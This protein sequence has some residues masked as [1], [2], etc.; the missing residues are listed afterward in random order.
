MSNSEQTSASN[1]LQQI[2][3]DDLAAGLNDGRVQTRFPPEPNGYLHIGHAKSICVNFGLAQQFGGQCNLRF[4]D[5]NPEKEEQEYID[6]IQE[7]V[8]W[9]GFEWSGEPRFA[10][11]YFD[12]F[13]EWALHLIREGKAYVCDLS[14]EQASEYRGWATKPG[15]ESPY[16]GRSVEENLSLFEKMRAGEFD[17][18]A[19]VLRANIDMASPNMNLRDPIL[20]RI[21]KESHHQTGDKWCI[22]P[23]YDF[24]HGQEDAIER[25]THSICTLEFQDHRP[26]YEW[27]HENLPVP[28]TPK[29]YEFAR[30][31]LNYTVTSKR[32]LKRLVDDAVVDGWDDP[33]MP[34]ISGMRRR[35]YT[36]AALR[37][38]C[39][40]IGTNR[41]DGIVDVGMLEFAL[42][43][44]LNENAAR[45]MCV[46][47]PLKIVITNFEADE[48]EVMKAPVHPN[49]EELGSR[50]LPFTRELY[51]DRS[52][53]TEDTSLSRKKFKRLVLGEYVRLRSAYVIRA[54]EV[55]RD[56]TGEI[57]EVKA[58]LVP[59]TVGENPPEGIRP[60]GV[61]HW[62][63]VS[64]GKQAKVRLY[65]R[66]FAHEAPDRG[67]QDFIEHL[68][69]DSLQVL[70]AC[71]VE[72]SVAEAAPE[73]R[74]QFEREGYF[75]IDRYDSSGE[76]LVIN[77]TIG[78]KDTWVRKGSA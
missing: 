41:S 27:F 57:V 21:R 14:A 52:D 30:L 33:R 19:C 29:Q 71:W 39:D 72:P 7:D 32:K 28:A 66:L 5:T 6:A 56:D 31:N 75:C 38:F 67:E 58:S 17:E 12:Q 20:Y 43:E 26:L 36:P 68:N 10:S 8:R 53:F 34:T 55:I 18:G 46:L 16:R 40:M 54:D 60:R 4:D 9:L 13:Y 3:R 74:F 11:S 1:F 77:K 62:V 15:R 63:S 70:D 50:E 65:D 78:L 69:P 35:G 51:I 23:S 76:T 42:R 44:D 37:K 47:N 73:T 24:A 22:Y 61:I 59:D 64:R 49:R 45:A 48:V 2:I 25:V